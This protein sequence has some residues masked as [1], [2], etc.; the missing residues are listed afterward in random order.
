MMILLDMLHWLNRINSP[1][2]QK[3]IDTILPH[4]D[5]KNYSKNR[6][7]YIESMIKLFN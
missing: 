6:G 5:K 4:V 7:N 3:A 2:T 1:D